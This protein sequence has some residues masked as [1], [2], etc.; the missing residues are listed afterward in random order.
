MQPYEIR[1]LR[2][3]SIDYNNYVARPVSLLTPNMRR[4][5]KQAMSLRLWL[6]LVVTAGVLAFLPLLTTAITPDSATAAGAAP[7]GKQHSLQH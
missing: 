4:Y 3:G 7:S 1:Q 5:C 6:I 2:D